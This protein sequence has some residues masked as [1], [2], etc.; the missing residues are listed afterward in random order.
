[1]KASIHLELWAGRIAYVV[2]VDV[3]W[4]THN[5]CNICI[6]GDLGSRIARVFS[7]RY[8]L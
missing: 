3:L 2:E 7:T 4:D 6:R 8:S 5:S 1:M